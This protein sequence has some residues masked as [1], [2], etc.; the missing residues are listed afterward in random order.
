Y[1]SIPDSADWVFGTGAFTVDGWFRFDANN[2]AYNLWSQFADVS[3]R[4][5]LDYAGQVG[6]P[7][8][9]FYATSG[10]ALGQYQFEWT[11]V[12]DTWYHI[13]LVR[14][15]ANLYLFVDGDLKTWSTILT[16][17]SAST[18]MP[19]LGAPFEIGRLNF[20]SAYGYLAGYADEFR[21]SDTARYTS[22]FTPSTT[23]FTADSNTKLLIHSD[24]D[25]GLGADSSGNTNDFSATN[26]V[27][28]DQMVDSP[29]N[30]FATLNPLDGNST[31]SEGN[32]KVVTPAS[33]YSNNRSTFFCPAG[34]KWYWEFVPTTTYNYAACGITTISHEWDINPGG[35]NSTPSGHGVGFYGVEVDVDG[36]RTSPAGNSAWASGDIIGFAYD[37]DANTIK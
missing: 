16:A 11:A 37:V 33:G 32:L 14:T 34:T 30:N 15:G 22:S 27:A 25:G 3:N 20:S 21:I 29:T 2:A 31:W 10:S 36:S 4:Y 35:G 6:T 7:Y 5:G 9:Q 17:I 24:F 26:L 1:L 23:A 8:L 13:A 18:D 19:D 28:T 12:A